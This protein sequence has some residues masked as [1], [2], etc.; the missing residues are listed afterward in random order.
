MRRKNSKHL[1]KR[2]LDEGKLKSSI[3]ERK[4][5]ISGK[6]II[7]SCSK[8]NYLK[9]IT[10][11]IF[12][13]KRNSFCTSFLIWKIGTPSNLGKY[14]YLSLYN[15]YNVN[16][17]YHKICWNII[18]IYIY[19]KIKKEKKYTSN[20]FLSVILNKPSIQNQLF[21]TVFNTNP[22]K[23]SFETVKKFFSCYKK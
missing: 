23:H 4:I 13:D 8:F 12:L 7:I 20:L 15:I 9:K 1:K 2:N 3:W 22:K 10:T 6:T 18:Y 19:I 11:K 21:W 5:K 16:N 17:I 14:L